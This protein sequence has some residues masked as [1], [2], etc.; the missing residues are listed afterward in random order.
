M[1]KI[2]LDELLRNR[3]S[4]PYSEQYRYIT[5]LMAADKIRPMKSAKSNGKRPALPLGYWLV[6]PETDY[7]RYKE[8][9][10][11]YLDPRIVPDFYMHHLPV[12]VKDRREVLQLSN[13]LKNHSADLQ[14]EV[15]ENE[16]SFAIWHR[17]KFLQRGP[18]FRILKNCGIDPALLAFYSTSEPLAYYA[19]QRSA[20][21]NILMIEN[22]DTFFSMRKVLLSGKRQILGTEIGTLIY[23]AGKGIW[24]SLDDFDLCV[25][26]YM[27][28]ENNHY[29]YFGDLDYEG[30]GI[31]DR[32][33]DI[34]RSGGRKIVPFT[35]AYRKMA[36]KAGRLGTEEL[37]ETREQQNRDIRQEFF[38]HFSRTE[39]GWMRNILE[40]GHYIP[41]EILN[42]SD[43]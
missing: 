30:I 11:F 29:L 17:E 3:R 20:G 40:S 26:P 35:A 38:N 33:R 9:L 21:Q 22:K 15:S 19:A 1:K 37:P 36:E 8:E 39:E 24:K 5:G 12:Y 31:Y 16:R 18:G 7:S 34:F 4:A 27:K 25:E 6:E 13:Y 23:G 14:T 41:Q 2:T 43:F 28:D 42:I 10:S 32:V